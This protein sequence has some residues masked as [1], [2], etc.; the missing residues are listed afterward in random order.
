MELISI[1]YVSVFHNDK[2]GAGNSHTSKA[3]NLVEKVMDVSNKK[4]LENSPDF[5][6]I[7]QDSP[8]HY[9]LV[10]LIIH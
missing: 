5:Y 8:L 9:S 2:R 10:M 1:Y 6:W 3:Y 7:L 4:I